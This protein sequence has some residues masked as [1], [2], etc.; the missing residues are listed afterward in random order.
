MYT[1]VWL[2]ASKFLPWISIC[3]CSHFYLESIRVPIPPQRGVGPR[4]KGLRDARAQ[5]VTRACLSQTWS[6]NHIPKAKIFLAG[7]KRSL[8][9]GRQWP[10]F[11]Q[12]LPSF[13]PSCERRRLLRSQGGREEWGEKVQKR[14]VP[15]PVLASLQVTF[16]FWWA[17]W[18]R[19]IIH[20]GK[21]QTLALKAM[22][23]PSHAVREGKSQSTVGR[24]PFLPAPCWEG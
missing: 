16:L 24:H 7:W 20:G 17:A 15:T 6:Y 13:P 2:N 21:L 23:G 19:S 18:G 1:C 10:L 14:A 11:T 9:K 22:P 12:L 8:S 4:S 5:V 3:T